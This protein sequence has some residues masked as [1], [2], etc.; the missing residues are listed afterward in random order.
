M[1]KKKIKPTPLEVVELYY[2]RYLEYENAFSKNPFSEKDRQQ[3]VVDIANSGIDTDSDEFMDKMIEAMI[4]KPRKV[5]DVNNAAA[6]FAM[7]T[8]FFLL[9]QEDELPENIQKDFDSLPIKDMIKTHFSIKDG[10]F[11]RNE[12]MK[13]DQETKDYF[14]AM[15]EQIK[16]QSK[17]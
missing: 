16:I 6:K 17:A 7:Y 10:E 2:S 4:D 5:A 12:D 8:E 11:V 15:I 13:V 14:K 3:E 9:T 1:S